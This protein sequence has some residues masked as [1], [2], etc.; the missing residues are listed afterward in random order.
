MIVTD[1]HRVPEV[2]PAALALVNPQR[3][4]ATYP[5]RRLAG[6]GVALKV[7]SL[8]LEQLAGI[9]AAAT[10][11]DLA[12]LAAIGTVADVAPI[13]GEN[14]SIAR[15]GLER[16]RTAP[17]PGIAALLASARVDPASVTLETIAFVIAPRL[18]AAG[19]MGEAADAAALLLAA[20]A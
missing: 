12:D 19:R 11:A 16:L 20:T 10:I 15:I 7:A 4:D 14:R 18:N 5:D 3:P 13:L 1:H 6:S 2:P 8:L 17:R 9:P